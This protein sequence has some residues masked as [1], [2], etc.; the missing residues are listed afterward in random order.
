[1]DLKFLMGNADTERMMRTLKEELIWLREWSNAEEVADALRAW[2]AGYNERYLHSA[3]GYKPPNE[4]ERS[5]KS[6]GDTF[7]E[8]A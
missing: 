8:V 4:V 2:I 5:W 1:M 3:H 6:N 7:L